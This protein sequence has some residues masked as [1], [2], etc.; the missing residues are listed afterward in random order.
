MIRLPVITASALFV[1]LAFFTGCGGG[2]SGDRS[3]AS[4]S[5]VSGMASRSVAGAAEVPS[6]LPLAG[7]YAVFRGPRHSEDDLPQG[8]IPR[9]IVL[10]LHLDT[11]QSRF[12]RYLDGEAA[13]LVP[14]QRSICL[15]SYNEAVGSCWP[16]ATLA[17]GSAIATTLCGPGLGAHQVVTFGVVPDGVRKVTVVRTNVPSRTVAV[18]GNVFVA[19]TS[20][21][22]PLPLRIF[23]FEGGRR[24]TRSAGI[25][26]KVAREGC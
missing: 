25:P 12:A 4:P 14:A 1:C 3:T 20:S 19:K 9:R 23:W 2:A 24:V 22:P 17:M 26:P 8:F 6:V 18:E 10:Q 15:F 5:D 11:G 7:D 21:K 16:P 13:Y